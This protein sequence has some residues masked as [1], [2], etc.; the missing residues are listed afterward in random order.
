MSSFCHYSWVT[1]RFVTASLPTGIFVYLTWLSVHAIYWLTIYKAPIYIVCTI[2]Q[3]RINQLLSILKISPFTK[4][5][6]VQESIAMVPICTLAFMILFWSAK[7]L[8]PISL[9]WQLYYK[10]S[11]K[12]LLSS[13]SHT[14]AIIVWRLFYYTLIEVGMTGSI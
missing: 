12:E 14:L 3:L 10:S 11:K 8:F 6:L 5:L 2:S 7:Y 4:T 1:S 9:K 13:S